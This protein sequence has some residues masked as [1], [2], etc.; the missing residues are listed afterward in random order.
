LSYIS[1]TSFRISS[2]D[3]LRAHATKLLRGRPLVV[4]SNRG[5]YKLQGGEWVRTVGGMAAVLEPIL[6][7]CGGVWLAQGDGNEAASAPPSGL[8]YRLQFLELPKSIAEGFYEGFANQAL[9]PLLHACYVRP[10]YERSHWQAF[11]EANQ[12]FA[13]AVLR[14]PDIANAVLFVQD[15]H[16][17]LVPQRIRVRC[18]GVR[19]GQFFHV[20]WPSPDTFATCP[21]S[22][23]LL[24]GIAG[25]DFVGF[26]CASY[27]SNFVDCAEKLG[28]GFLTAPQERWVE[29]DGRRT[30]VRDVPAGIDDRRLRREGANPAVAAAAERLRGRFQLDGRRMVFSIDRCDYTKGIGERLKGIERLLERNPQLA[31]TV[32]FV[33]AISP[34]RESLAS[35]REVGEQAVRWASEINERF[36]PR[37][38]APVVL[39][40]E[41]VSE[42][43]V[44]AFYRLAYAALVTPLRDGMNLVAKEFI[45]SRP[46]DSGGLILSQFAGA[47]RELTEAITI[48]P[49]DADDVADGIESALQMDLAEQ[50]RRMAALRRKVAEQNVYQWG[51]QLLV[52]LS[53]CTD[54]G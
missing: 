39:L 36:S 10:R 11:T 14:I 27:T 20:P 15:F 29:R 40:R 35:F 2:E 48:N 30:A 54:K 8:N 34:S 44:L 28:G 51:A 43:D 13:D 19:M 32:V 33:Q 4:L 22:G 9:W 38:K 25:N 23:Q 26:N 7:S 1:P 45:A 37:G 42:E 3:E 18:P 12:M 50:A 24:Q 17:A 49:Y 41:R 21:W 31:E 6:Q 52:E 53:T 47:A 5:P 46:G 16:L